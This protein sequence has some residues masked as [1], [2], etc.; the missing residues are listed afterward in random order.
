M[1]L[2][3]AEFVLKYFPE[4][5]ESLKQT[6]MQSDITELYEKYIQN[7][8]IYS[9]LMALGTGAYIFIIF[10]YVVNFGFLISIVTSLMFFITTFFVSLFAYHSYPFQLMESKR[11]SIET[12]LPFAINHMAAVAESGVPP[13]IMFKLLSNANEYG[14]MATESKK[15]V[16]NVEIFGMD[17]VRAIEE[18]ANRTPSTELRRFLYGVVSTIETGGDLRLYLKTSSEEAIMNYRMKREKYLSALSTYADF[19]T[20]LLIAAPLFFIS[21][22][23]VMSLVGGQVMGMSIHSAMNLGVYVFMPILNL[24]FLLFLQLTQPKI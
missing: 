4:Y 8:I 2:K 20:A 23:S 17:I 1:G 13:Y 24:L 21:T 12:N 10:N 7:M 9:F 22:L 6:L 11:S 3:I 5:F 16:R 15:I 18:V 14:E 19:Y